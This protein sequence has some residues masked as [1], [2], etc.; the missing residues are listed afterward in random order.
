MPG[1]PFSGG[2]AARIMR[3]PY[4]RQSVIRVTACQAAIQRAFRSLFHGVRSLRDST[5]HAGQQIEQARQRLLRHPRAR[6][7]ARQT[8]GRGRPPHP[9]AE[10]RQPGTVRFRSTG[11]DP[12]G[13]HPQPAD[14]TGLQRFQGVVQRAQGGD[15]VLPAEAGRR[16]L[17]RGHLPRQRRLRAD[18]HGHA[19]PAQQ[20]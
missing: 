18:R 8:P 7:Q 13:R 10:H 14:R 12:P 17:H 4:R 5:H 3:A 19:G 15:A 9:Q 1:A 20:R 16:R 6:A 11:R 2:R